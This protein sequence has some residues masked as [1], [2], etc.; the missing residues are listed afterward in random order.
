MNG[1]D[2]LKEGIVKVGNIALEVIEKYFGGD[3]QDEGKVKVANRVVGHSLK[4]MH[5]SQ[6]AT[7]TNRSQALR[8]LKYLPNDET[9]KEYIKL[10]QPDTQPLLLDRPK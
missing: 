8:L 6:V 10:T 9:R 1:E 5:M 4:V 2:K 3:D 7:L